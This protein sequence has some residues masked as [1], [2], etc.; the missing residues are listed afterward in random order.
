ML[1]FATVPSFRRVARN[2]QLPTGLTKLAQL[3]I[4]FDTFVP[5]GKHRSPFQILFRAQI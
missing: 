2:P 3:R 5:I 4:V 1:V